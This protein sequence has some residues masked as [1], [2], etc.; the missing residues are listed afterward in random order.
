MSDSKNRGIHNLSKA[1]YLDLLSELPE[2]LRSEHPKDSCEKIPPFPASEKTNSGLGISR[3]HASC[4]K[5][6]ERA[7][8]AFPAK[9]TL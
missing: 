5:L 8:G 1:T 6:I 9:S 4:L 2:T 7:V 3:I